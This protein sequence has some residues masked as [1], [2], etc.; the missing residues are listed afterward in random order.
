MKAVVDELVHLRPYWY[1]SYYQLLDASLAFDNWQAYELFREEWQKGVF[2]AIRRRFS[3]VDI[4]EIK[5]K[6]LLPDQKHLIHNYDDK[7]CEMDFIKSGKELMG[8]G[9]SISMGTG[10]MFVY[11]ISIVLNR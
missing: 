7:K 6:G 4:Q 10:S 3:Q 1:G 11:D 5:L 9:F 2:A 8:E